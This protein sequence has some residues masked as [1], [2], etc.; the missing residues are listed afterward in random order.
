M[1]GSLMR[2][3]LLPLGVLAAAIVL[4]L[5]ASG[6]FAVGNGLRT[7]SAE[8]GLSARIAARISGVQGRRPLAEALTLLQEDGG[9]VAAQLQRRQRASALLTRLS[10]RGNAQ[11]SNILGV[12]AVQRAKSDPRSAQQT[13]ADAH[14]A[15]VTAIRADP[16]GE[17]AKFNLELL[18][19]QQAQRM[20]QPP[21]AQATKPRTGRSARPSG[22]GF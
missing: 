3:S 18:L 21:Q 11:A 22:S 14:A 7:S 10:A 5:L 1:A 15:F 17:T 12:L 16:Q 19:A 13:L 2:R 20:H 8:S 9:S 6:A 4:G